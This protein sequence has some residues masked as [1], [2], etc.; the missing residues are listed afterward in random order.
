MVLG[1]SVSL[2]SVSVLEDEWYKVEFRDGT[3]LVQ[4]ES[5]S[6]GWSGDAWHQGGSLNRLL[7][8]FVDSFRGSL[9]LSNRGSLVVG[10]SDC[11][12]ESDNC[13]A[14][15]GVPRMDMSP[16]QSSMWVAKD[17]SEGV[18][19]AIEGVMVEQSAG[20]LS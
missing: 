3:M 18:A 6:P 2:L 9:E 1:L 4:C 15:M 7:G 19:T 17:A 5:R 12:F 11:L 8:Q 16:F 13:E 10:T 14:P 20:P